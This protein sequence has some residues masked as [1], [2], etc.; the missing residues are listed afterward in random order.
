MTVTEI[1]SLLHKATADLSRIH[2]SDAWRSLT[3]S[4]Q[5]HPQIEQIMGDAQHYITELRLRVGQSLEG[6]TLTPGLEQELVNLFTG[7]EDSPVL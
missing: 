4:P 1:I 3:E 2:E 6:P 5:A 7:R